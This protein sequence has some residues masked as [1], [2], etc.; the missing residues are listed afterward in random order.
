MNIST[1]NLVPNEIKAIPI[2][3]LTALWALSESMLGGL[4]HASHV[5]FRG[6]IISS[7]AIIIMILIAHF[8]KKRGEIFRATIL[9]LMVKAALSPHTPILAYGVVFLQGLMGELFFLTKKHFIL[10][11][12]ALG[13][14]VEIFTGL[15][16]VITFTLVFGMTLWDALNQFISFVVKEFLSF[17]ADFSSFNFSLILVISY[18]LIHIL[19]GIAAVLFALRLRTK[20]SSDEVKNLILDE[21]HSLNLIS[22][23]INKTSKRSHWLR[24]PVYVVIFIISLA[25]LILSYLDPNAINLS[26][27]SLLIML[28]RAILIIVIW[29]FF[30]SPLLLKL[31]KKILHQR[32]NKYAVE[33]K[34]IMRHLP[35]YKHIA[36]LMWKISSKEKGILR[37][38]HF[39]TALIINVLVLKLPEN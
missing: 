17:S 34:D 25:F 37:I 4:L 8:S 38:N 36:M 7:V 22:D 39:L 23:K 1:K 12:I 5:P 27:H 9:V 10:S 26:K 13:I 2:T 16:R 32:Q 11:S 21:I 14:A 33:I 24:K 35:S 15:H 6:M 31:F 18:V 29:F 20:I 30:L 28:L 19:F 3:R